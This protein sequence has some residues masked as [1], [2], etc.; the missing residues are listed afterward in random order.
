MQTLCS[1]IRAAGF[2][3]RQ[4][5]YFN[6]ILFPIIAAIR[7]A[8]RTFPFLRG[9]ELRSDFTMTQPGKINEC[10]ARIFAFES[11]LLERFQ[12]PFGVSILAVAERKELPRASCP[13]LG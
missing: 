3:V 8:R 6:S 5:T 2:R 10:L 12:L 9:R 13:V 7:L 11:Q 1:R 4:V